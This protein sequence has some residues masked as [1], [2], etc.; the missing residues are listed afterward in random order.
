[1]TKLDEIKKTRKFVKENWESIEFSHALDLF[2]DQQKDIDWLIEKLEKAIKTMEEIKSKENIY[3]MGCDC[4]EEAAK[5]LK[6]LIGDE[7]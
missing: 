7:K 2:R 3:S 4:D 1:M 6:D 5:W